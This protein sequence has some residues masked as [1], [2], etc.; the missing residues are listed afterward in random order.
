[1]S[2]K[3]FEKARFELAAK[4][5]FRLGRAYCYA[6]LQAG[7]AWVAWLNTEVVYE[8]VVTHLSTNPA[9][10]RVTSLMLPIM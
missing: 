2:G 6:E 8:R 3:D 5:T 1:M 4:G 10:C 9:Q 7:L